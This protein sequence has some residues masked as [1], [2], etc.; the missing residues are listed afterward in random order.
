[1]TITLTL[2]EMDENKIRCDVE[3]HSTHGYGISV[4]STYKIVFDERTSR[5]TS[6]IGLLRTI[7]NIVGIT[8]G[9]YECGEKSN[10]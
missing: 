8:H 6:L 5:S 1:M 7:Y 9:L 2:S 4:D 3:I 10:E